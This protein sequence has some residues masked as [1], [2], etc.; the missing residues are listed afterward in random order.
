[1]RGQLRATLPVVRCTRALRL[2][3]TGEKVRGEKKKELKSEAGAGTHCFAEAAQA[4]RT[5]QDQGWSD[6]PTW[7]MLLDIARPAPPVA[8]DASDWPH[9]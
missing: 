7:H 6:C 1:M 4:H 8:K 3:T 9:G 2:R 5:L